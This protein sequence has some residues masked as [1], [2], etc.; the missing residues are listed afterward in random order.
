MA[1]QARKNFTTYTYVSADGTRC[2]LQAG[3]DGVT[4][5]MIRFLAESDHEQELQERC[6]AEHA[7]YRYR[8]AVRHFEQIPNEDGDH[9]LERI[10]DPNA[11]ILKILF[12][13]EADDS[14]ALQRLETA[15]EQLT[16]SQRELIQEL[17]GLQRSIVDVAREEGVTEG[18]I[19]NR[20]SKILCRL[21]K[22]MESDG[23]YGFPAYSEG[24]FKE[25]LTKKK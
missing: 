7:D 15:M 6:Q 9:P 17:F 13:E 16:D 20:R 22:L 24:V 25:P 8:N 19:R 2:T 1:N 14:V 21:K 12:P 10:A 3:Q 18:A 23:G 5:E 4:E 11:D